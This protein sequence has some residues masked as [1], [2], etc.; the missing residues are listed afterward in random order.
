[1]SPRSFRVAGADKIIGREI[2]GHE[3]LCHFSPCCLIRTVEARFIFV[4]TSSI[5]FRS[6]QIIRRSRWKLHRLSTSRRGKREQ[7]RFRHLQAER[8][9][10]FPGPPELYALPIHPFNERP[11][12]RESDDLLP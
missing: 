7:I 10:L 3:P 5:T 1:M 9:Q 2:T 8:R 4:Q 11:H 12:F 6:N